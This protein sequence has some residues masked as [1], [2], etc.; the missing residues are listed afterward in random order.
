MG[1]AE[2][3]EEVR[4]AGV[5]M[6]TRAS[7]MDDA[8]RGA[9]AALVG[10]ITVI[11]VT[12]SVPDA[13]AVISRLRSEFGS[14]AVIGAGTVLTR[15]QARIALDAGA[16]FLVSPGFDE[17]LVTRGL[18]ADT[19]VLPGVLT[20]TEIMR[21]RA[22]GAIAVKLFPASAVGP[23]YIGAMTAPM[24]GL[25]IV[26]SGGISSANAG[27]WITAGAAAIGVGGAL[28]PS[29]RVDAEAADAITAEARA[30]VAAVAAARTHHH[31]TKGQDT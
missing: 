9:T 10:G 21:A 11:E 29:W 17:D 13:G 5:I 4:R 8:I 22:A 15:E 3:L 12:F 19:L 2:T 31:A 23:G 28:S 14:A 25:Q 27:E 1:A 20:A 7:T 6:I 24:P 18:A 26:P 30:C 16:S